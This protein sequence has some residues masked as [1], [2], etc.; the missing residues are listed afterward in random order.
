[1][2]LSEL[3][4]PTPELPSPV[5][6]AN[7]AA[8]A[9][10]RVIVRLAAYDGDSPQVSLALDLLRDEA[11]ATPGLR[12]W[13]D[14]GLILASLERSRLPLLLANLPKPL[15]AQI[16]TIYNTNTETP[17]TL[18]DRINGRLRVDVIEA[19]GSATQRR[20]FGGEYRL[21]IRILAPARGVGAQEQDSMHLELLPQHYSPAR[22]LLVHEPREPSR[23]GWNFDQ[24]HLLRPISGEEVWLITADPEPRRDTPLENEGPQP[25]SAAMPL[26]LGEAMLTGEHRGR[27]VRLVVLIALEEEK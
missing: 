17:I 4:T 3:A 2:K 9:P 23:Q 1:M 6:L 25:R 15:A 19:D 22:S 8:A 5:A 13:R 27:P 26:T 20:F 24:L 7:V 21:L 18:I 12:L 16:L 10:R 14:N 11:P